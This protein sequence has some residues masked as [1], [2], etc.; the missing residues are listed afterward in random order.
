MTLVAT[1]LPFH[2]VLQILRMRITIT[3]QQSQRI[4]SCVTFASILQNGVARRWTFAVSSRLPITLRQTPTNHRPSAI[5]CY[6][7]NG[8]APKEFIMKDKLPESFNT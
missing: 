8:A 7:F 5:A 4:D 3:F 2:N 6:A 1:Y